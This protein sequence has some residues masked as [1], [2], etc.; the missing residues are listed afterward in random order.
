MRKYENSNSY[1]T[2]TNDWTAVDP[3]L[4]VTY[5]PITYFLKER[6]IMSF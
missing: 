6:D 2:F 1:L 3:V 5:F 4:V